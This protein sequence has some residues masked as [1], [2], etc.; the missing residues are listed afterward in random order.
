MTL[1]RFDSVRL[2]ILLTLL[3]APIAASAQH[4]SILDGRLE[5]NGADRP[6]AGAIIEL[7][8]TETDRSYTLT[9]DKKGRFVKPGLRP[10]LY[11]AVIKAEGFHSLAVSGITIRDSEICRVV[12]Q[13][14][15]SN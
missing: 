7:V 13:M 1:R 11:T 9:T 6:V 15:P 4:V 3:V 5:V 14:K 10:G 2:A 12:L 8:H